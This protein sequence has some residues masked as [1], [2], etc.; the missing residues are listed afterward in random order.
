MSDKKTN[1]ELDEL[2]EKETV[3]INKLE[4]IQET[5][6]DVCEIQKLQD[7]Y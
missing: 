7:A 6:K 5:Y 3:L 4:A 2:I 1:I